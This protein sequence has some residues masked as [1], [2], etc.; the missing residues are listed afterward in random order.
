M[1]TPDHFFS[2]DLSWRIFQKWL[3]GKRFFFCLGAVLPDS[4]M[5]IV[6]F[7]EWKK[8]L[9]HHGEWNWPAAVQSL[10]D[11]LCRHERAAVV[12]SFFHALNY[13]SLALWLT[14][15]L[16]SLVFWL[17]LLFVCFIFSSAR[18]AV[19]ATAYGAIIFHIALDWLTHTSSAHRYFWPLLERQLPGLVA[20]DNHWLLLLQV[21]IAIVWFCG[22]FYSL[23]R[24]FIIAI[25]GKK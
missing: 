7:I 20:Q 24:R 25:Y 16:H 4:P 17:A 1:L 18:G 22:V 23:L 3:P 10:F 5:L 8:Y 14:Q 6:S 21:A 9:V 13:H 12:G 15:C 2:A 11:I 19:A